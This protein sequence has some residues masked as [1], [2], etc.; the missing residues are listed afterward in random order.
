MITELNFAVYK[1]ED[2]QKF[3]EIADDRQ[4]LHDT[5][6]EWYAEFSE[7]KLMFVRQGYLVRDITIDLDD[8]IKYCKK[9]N[10]K[11]DGKTRSI[12]VNR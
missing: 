5:W 3:L 12:Y 1:K 2:W 10:V 7:R 9:H 8:L 4:N 11:N 6:E